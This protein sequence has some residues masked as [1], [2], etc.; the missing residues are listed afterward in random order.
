[1]KKCMQNVGDEA[2][3]QVVLDPKMCMDEIWLFWVLL[4]RLSGI[5]SWF[6]NIELWC[7]LLSAL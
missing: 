7:S 5:A 4:V 6:W 1:M 3:L 2:T